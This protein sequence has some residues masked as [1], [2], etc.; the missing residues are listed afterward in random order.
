MK[1]CFLIE[2]DVLIFNELI[3]MLLKFLVDLIW[4]GGIGIYIKLL[5]E[6][7]FDVGDKVND[8]FCVNGCD[9]KVKVI[10][11]GGNLGII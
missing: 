5:K 6:Q 1:D 4:N 10:G 3:L 8:V 7:Y 2:V 9:V 11:E